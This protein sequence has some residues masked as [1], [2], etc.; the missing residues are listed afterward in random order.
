MTWPEERQI[1]WVSISLTVLSG[2]L[3]WLAFCVLPADG[4]AL[5][6]FPMDDAWIHQVY[7]RG[8]IHDGL[9][10]Y[11]PGEPEAGFSSALWLLVQVP[12]FWVTELG[13]GNFAIASKLMS[14]L[15]ALATAWGIG[16]LAREL[17]G[18][19][20]GRSLGSVLAVLTPGFAFSAVSGME[21]TLAAATVTWALLTFHR[22]RFGTCGILL[23]L[24][25]LARPELGLMAAI[26]V[27]VAVVSSGSKER[28]VRLVIK[29]IGPSIVLGGVW[30]FY[31][32]A[33]TGHPLPNTFYV[34]SAGSG[35]A[36]Q[37]SGYLRVVVLNGG[38]PWFTAT[39]ALFAVGCWRALR[40]S[41]ARLLTVT[42]LVVQ[43][44]GVL[45]VLLTRGGPAMALFSYHRYFLPLT[46][47][48]SVFVAVG[49]VAVADWVARASGRPWLGVLASGMPLFL[50]VGPLSQATR[51]YEGH[52][53]DIDVLHTQPALDAFEHTPDDFVIA[54]E[55]AGAARF[56]SERRTLDL[57]GLN[58]YPLAHV[59]DDPLTWTCLMIGNR[60]DLF[61]VPIEWLETLEAAF[62]IE[63]IE[64]YE[65]PRWMAVG[66]SI[67]RTVVAASA[68]VR[69]GTHALCAEQFGD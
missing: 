18:A 32:L 60:P 27:V 21:V 65:R 38:W 59:S 28:T 5:T 58:Y 6:E 10:T 19:N 23:G 42:I 2:V 30:V 55:G 8:L 7:V 61:L 37:V 20:L 3:V 44:F 54:V 43:V 67:G 41:E 36:E 1:L 15:F 11:N 17:S 22:N 68:R 64:L 51:S 24:A 48:D 31:N 40:S 29:L 25:G 46:I 14:L 12:S 4:R 52:C 47:L 16:L 56:F 26:L 39:A 53:V 35:V 49:L 45:G 50:I 66:G 33:V 9:P 62:E 69:S 13:G 63:A 34:K 57:L